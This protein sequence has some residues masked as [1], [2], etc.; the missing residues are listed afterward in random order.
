MAFSFTN[1][2][3]LLEQ[4]I[5]FIEFL[6]GWFPSKSRSKSSL[7]HSSHRVCLFFTWD[8]IL[9]TVGGKN[10]TNCKVEHVVFILCRLVYEQWF[11]KVVHVSCVHTVL[12]LQ[13]SLSMIRHSTIKKRGVF[14]HICLILRFRCSL[15]TEK[16]TVASNINILLRQ[17]NQPWFSATPISN[18]KLVLLKH[19]TLS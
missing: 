18:V 10:C 11:R 12:L 16:I 19:L 3:S 1:T 9:S 17:S 6:C 7:S 14:I 8:V 15:L 2:A 4:F 13:Q 5:L